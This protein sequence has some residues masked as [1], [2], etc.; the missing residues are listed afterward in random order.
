MDTYL[1][2]LAILGGMYM[3]GRNMRTLRYFGH[4]ISNEERRCEP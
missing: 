2:S 1:V 3:D 4:G